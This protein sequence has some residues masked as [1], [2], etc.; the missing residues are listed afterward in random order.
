MH[1]LDI[2]ENSIT[3]GAKRIEVAVAEDSA[4]DTFTVRVEDDGRGIDMEKK[5][6][7]PYYTTKEKKKKFGLGIPFLRQAA[8]MCDG[9]FNIGPRSQG[10]TSVTAKF[11]LSH[12]DRMPLGDIGATMSA[13]VCGNPDADFAFAYDKDGHAY[14]F[15]TA[16]LRR[17][18]DGLPLSTPQVLKYIKDELNDAIRRAG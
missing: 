3:A 14:R 18:L 8:E 5:S 17:E 10:G 16:E 2:A 4:N 12:I 13:L 11:R 7:D 6:N 9:S 15:D 1:I